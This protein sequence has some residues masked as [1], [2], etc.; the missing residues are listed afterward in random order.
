MSATIDSRV[1]RE[2]FKS[3]SRN[4]IFKWEI[5]CARLE[6]KVKIK[7]PAIIFAVRRTESV[8]GRIIRLIISTQTIN[9]D[10][11]VGVPRGTKWAFI[12]WIFMIMG[13]KNETNHN[14]K[15]RGRFKDIWAVVANV[16]GKRPVTLFK[17]INMKSGV[18]IFDFLN[19]LEKIILFSFIREFFNIDRA[20]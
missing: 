14:E 17:V 19:N 16:Y 1:I 3:V 20:E 6:I 8:I 13:N 2:V 18:N 12:I 10:M 11:A 5:W 15:A 7:W 4:L 9:G